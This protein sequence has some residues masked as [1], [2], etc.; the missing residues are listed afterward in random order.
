MCSRGQ[1]VRNMPYI[2]IKHKKYDLLPLCKE[3]GGE[4]FEYPLDLI[5]QAEDLIALSENLIPYGYNSYNE[6]FDYIDE[7]TERIIFLLFS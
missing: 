6:Y 2:P 4:V 1:E 7:Y 3:T 5:S